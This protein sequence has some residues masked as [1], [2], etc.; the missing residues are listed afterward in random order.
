MPPPSD[1]ITTG[2]LGRRLDQ[3]GGTI[4]EALKDLAKKIDDRPDWQDVR[5]IEAALVERVLNEKAAREAERLVAD[6]AISGLEE[7]NRYAVR[8]CAGIGA[9]LVT[10]WL[11]AQAVPGL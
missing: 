7:W 4:T 5:R 6:K 9:T 3:F 2:E 1:E 8:W 10:A 11:V